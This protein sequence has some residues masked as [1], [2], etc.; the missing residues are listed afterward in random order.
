MEKKNGGDKPP[1]REGNV[2]REESRNEGGTRPGVRTQG[3][4]RCSFTKT[5]RYMMFA[6]GISEG[7]QRT[8]PDRDYYYFSGGIVLIFHIYIYI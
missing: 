1:L 2:S 8:A 3:E 6:D 4:L 7:E 5:W